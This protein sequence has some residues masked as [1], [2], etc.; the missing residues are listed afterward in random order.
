MHADRYTAADATL[1]PTGELAPVA[2]TGLDFTRPTPIGDRIQQY[3]PFAKGYDHNFVLQGGGGK[4]APC[5]RVEDPQS[6]RVMEIRTTEPGVQL[7]T[8]NGF[9][10][11]STVGKGQQA[12]RQSDGL[13]LEPQKFPDSPNHPAFPSARL[14]PGGRSSRRRRRKPQPSGTG[15]P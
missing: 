5:A 15:T 9:D 12:Y 4:L 10:G 6:G 11:G 14:D 13:A 7:Y 1:I 8:G 3:Y 2:G